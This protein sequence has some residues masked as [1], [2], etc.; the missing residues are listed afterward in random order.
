MVLCNGDLDFCEVLINKS[1]I[2]ESIDDIIN[3][4]EDFIEC[5][6]K[7]NCG[8]CECFTKIFNALNKLKSK[9]A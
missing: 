2:K 4:T 1:E 3:I 8:M 9:V 6:P 5:D 7:E